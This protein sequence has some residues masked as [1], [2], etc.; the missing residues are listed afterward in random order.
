MNVNDDAKNVFDTAI[1][2]IM[3][4]SLNIIDGIKDPILVP[5]IILKAFGITIAH[6][7]IRSTYSIDPFVSN[8][9]YLN[10]EMTP[11][12]S[13]TIDGITIE[14]APSI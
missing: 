13:K 10:D 14:K 11:L 6:T 12:F 4:S 5:I 2:S 3:T 1:K 7:M 8:L 9:L